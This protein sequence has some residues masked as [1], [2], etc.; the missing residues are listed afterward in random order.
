MCDR[1]TENVRHQDKNFYSALNKMGEQ[2]KVKQ[3]ND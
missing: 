3:K 1:V 2:E